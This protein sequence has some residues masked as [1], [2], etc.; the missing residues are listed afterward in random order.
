MT[1]YRKCEF[2]LEL[3]LKA[4][5]ESSGA[6]SFPSQEN[7]YEKY[8][9]IVAQL[10][11]DVY[12]NVNSGLAALSDVSGLYTDH[13][14]EHFD[15]VVLYAGHLL[16]MCN[17]SDIEKN[18][19][20]IVSETW[21]LTHYELYLLLLS[22]R[23]HDVGNYFGR[24]RHEQ[25]ISKVIKEFNITHLVNNGIEARN[26][27]VVGGAHGGKTRGGSKDTIGSLNEDANADGHLHGLGLRKIAAITR[28]ADEICENR[29]R[30]GEL[31][32]SGI[33]P[34]NLVYHKYAYCIKRNYVKDK[35]LHL[36]LEVPVKDFLREYRIDNE[37]LV[38]LP[39]IIKQRLIKTELERRYCNRFLPEGIQVKQVSVTIRIID[40]EDDEDTFDPKILEESS[41]TLRETEYP[42]YEEFII[43]EETN[44]F[45]NVEYIKSLTKESTE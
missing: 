1:D 42:R 25:N 31:I 8:C 24:E 45:L 21:A 44:N 39:S 15:Q 20:A 5:S 37:E 27:C 11:K 10:R 12:P 3:A 4:A 36:G 6:G 18:Q 29:F 43:D 41:F 38:D 22:I 23:F 9:D 34:S 2:P 26:V 32:E 13:G 33:P 14:G 28:F 30:T 19:D 35:T 40:D 16:G 17:V 7:Y